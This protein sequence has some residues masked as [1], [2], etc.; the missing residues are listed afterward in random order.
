MSI[1]KETFPEYVTQQLK[2]REE[3]ISNKGTQPGRGDNARFFQ[4]HLNRTCTLRLS[5]GVDVT[6]ENILETS[7]RTGNPADIAKRW[8]LDGGIKKQPG[9]FTDLKAGFAKDN[10]AY[11]GKDTRSDSSYDGFGIVPMPG[12]VDAQINT[13]SAYGSLRSAKVKFVC[14]NRRQLE[15]LELLYMRPGYTLLLEWGWSNYT[16]NYK[17]ATEIEAQ[18]EVKS[19]NL[20]S[21][22]HVQSKF[23]D[24]QT[25][26]H[27]LE[28]EIEKSRIYTQGNYDALIGYCK[29]FNY[30]S[31][32]DGGY[33]CETEIIAKG[34]MLE[35]LKSAERDFLSYRES[36][37]AKLPETQMHPMQQILEYIVSYG[38]FIK[39]RNDMGW[40]SEIDK[41]E[42]KLI[43]K[44]LKKLIW[45]GSKPDGQS[46]GIP[47]GGVF[48]Y[49]I[50][51]DTT[52]VNYYAAGVHYNK[53][54]T[55]YDPKKL[56]QDN[57]AKFHW[58]MNMF[59]TSYVRWDALCAMI[60]NFALPKDDKGKNLF[61]FNTHELTKVRMGK[62]KIHDYILPLQMS[63][64]AHDI[65]DIQNKI[66]HVKNPDAD[67]RWY[68]NYEKGFKKLQWN[69]YDG[70]ID[71]GVCRFP[72]DLWRFDDDVGLF[73]NKKYSANP[74]YMASKIWDRSYVSKDPYRSQLSF[75]KRKID[76][77]TKEKKSSIGHIYL[78]AEH[79][80]YTFK[81]EYYDGD[82]NPKKS[83]TMF[84]FIERIWDDV[85][86]SCGP[87]HNFK[88]HV[89][90]VSK[91][92]V[93]VIDRQVDSTEIN[94]D[95]IHELK[96]Q[97]LD[98]ICRSF[99]YSTSIP[100]SLT[101]TIAISAQSPDSVEDIEA[102][103]FDA[104]N[105][106]IKDRFAR[107]KDEDDSNPSSDQKKK[108]KTRFDRNLKLLWQSIHKRDAWHPYR[109]R[110]WDQ[111]EGTLMQMLRK[112]EW[113]DQN[114]TY[115]YGEYD[116]QTVPEEKSKYASARV[117]LYKAMRY[118]MK[119]YGSDG[120][121]DG[122]PY[123]KGQPRRNLSNQRISAIIPLK[124]NAILDGIS[125]IRIG[126]VFKVQPDRLPKGYQSKD[127]HFIVM[128]ESQKITSGQ[129]WTTELKGNLILLGSNGLDKGDDGWNSSYVGYYE[130]GQGSS[131]AVTPQRNLQSQQNQQ[132][133]QN[134]QNK[135]QSSNP[136]T[137]YAVGDGVDLGNPMPGYHDGLTDSAYKKFDPTGIYC[138]RVYGNTAKNQRLNRVGDPRP[139][140]GNDIVTSQFNFYWDGN[141]IESS[142]TEK[143]LSDG[144]IKF[145]KAVPIIAPA[146]GFVKDWKSNPGGYGR[147]LDL[148]HD[149]GYATRYGHVQAY[150]IKVGDSFKRGDVIAASGGGTGNKD[151]DGNSTGPHIHYEIKKNGTYENPYHHL[152]SN[153]G[154]KQQDY[155]ELYN[156]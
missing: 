28:G 145:E 115:N 32:R 46:G 73:S 99:S 128:G 129:D 62:K 21:Y 41:D 68:N 19:F 75:D 138:G 70:T 83:F 134:V 51:K 91:D 139:H 120:V 61:T 50:A 14:H 35:S 60:N 71:T 4:Q 143:I 58:G 86:G 40:D 142:G 121:Y 48:P 79:L 123:Y 33:D 11:G 107:G 136:Y 15:I 63:S 43:V 76:L 146:D 2:I 85:N 130:L 45:E 153:G 55:K 24:K 149:N 10:G 9:G 151:F 133:L 57:D 25:K 127:V 59:M 13:K 137:W 12:I 101:A 150:F 18:D 53:K 23:W 112:H 64:Y 54:E 26:Q 154:A 152:V 122:K 22:M 20:D 126:N 44:K 89:D 105:R 155:A 119:V 17:D 39:D 6:D 103:T 124:F 104:I 110:F 95:D 96:I 36:E 109:N 8:V 125:G 118:F 106:G 29:N 56:K 1:F 102:V 135:T 90:H 97:G 156:P 49:I 98:S 77:T 132:N 67:G 52:F 87:Q 27:T 66:T 140:N 147:Y 80:L 78:A 37:R 94:I 100:S 31:R 81:K 69:L 82:G 38:D 131:A 141:V 7:E 16:V 93:K 108:W 111:A 88:L 5:S 117:K 72:I 30:S 42:K 148:T 3:I 144:T 114:T 74:R 84:K 34:E 65:V 113:A 47:Q 116:K 92:I